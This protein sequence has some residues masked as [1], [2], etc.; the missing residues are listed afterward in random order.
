MIHFQ[1][2][3]FPGRHG[4]GRVKSFSDY[5]DLKLM[6]QVVCSN[7]VFNVKTIPGRSY[8]KRDRFNILEQLRSQKYGFKKIKL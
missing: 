1:M 5:F 6:K 7:T 3:T 4:P 8:S 2:G